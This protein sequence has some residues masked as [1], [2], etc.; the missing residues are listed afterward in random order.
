MPPPTQNL[1]W[2]GVVINTVDMSVTL[3]VEKVSEVL[4]ECKAWEKKSL[5][6]KKQLQNLA[7][8]LQRMSKCIKLATQFFNRV[9][10]A[11]S[12]APITGLH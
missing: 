4:V 5:A 12:A 6:S 11:L 7:G 10:A 3:P 9:L 8:R 2:L 1:T